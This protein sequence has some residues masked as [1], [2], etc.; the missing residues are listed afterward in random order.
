VDDSRDHAEWMLNSVAI[1]QAVAAQLFIPAEQ[2]TIATVVPPDQ[3]LAANSVNSAGTNTTRVTAAA[4]G[5]LL[6][7]LLG[8]DGTVT[9]TVLVLGVAAVLIGFLP[10]DVTE[11]MPGVPRP[12]TSVWRDWIDGIRELWPNDGARAVM[13][14]QVLTA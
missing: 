3:L 7:G 4:L 6:I 8:F 10:K 5:G 2:R 13:S 11:H 9:A 1:L 14:L 12:P